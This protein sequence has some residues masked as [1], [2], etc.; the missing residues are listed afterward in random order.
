MNETPSIGYAS[1]LL[2]TDLP[3]RQAWLDALSQVYLA[4][5]SMVIPDQAALGNLLWHLGVAL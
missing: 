2:C 3:D 4:N 5:H 1:T